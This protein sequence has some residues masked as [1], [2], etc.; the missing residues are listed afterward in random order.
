MGLEIH[1]ETPIQTFYSDPLFDPFGLRSGLDPIAGIP[2]YGLAPLAADLS[3]LALE[4]SELRLESDPH[5]SF[6]GDC[7]RVVDQ[8]G[9]APLAPDLPPFG[10]S[11]EQLL[12][13]YAMTAARL[14]GEL[15]IRFGPCHEG[16]VPFAIDDRSRLSG[17]NGVLAAPDGYELAVE[18][19]EVSLISP[20]SRGL[21]EPATGRAFDLH[22]NC[23]FHNTAI[24]RLLELNPPM[25]A[26]PL[27]F[28]GLPHS[29]H[30]LAWFTASDDGALCFK[31]ACQMFLPLGEGAPGG[32][33]TMPASASPESHQE[34]F[35]ARNSSLHPFLF[36]T[37][38]EHRAAETPPLRQRSPKPTGSAIAEA[39]AE[40]ENTVLQ[41]T[42]LPRETYFGDDFD[43]VSADLG[44]GG[45]A[46]SPLFG[47]VSVQLGRI[48][49]GFVPFRLGFS[50]PSPAFEPKFASL[51]QLLP[52]GTAPG[53]VG[54]RGDFAFAKQLYR[55]RNLSLNTDPYKVSI[56][57]VEVET[58]EIRRAVLRKFL[59]QDLML[60]L[61]QTE[62]RTPTDSFAYSATGAFQLHG[63][64]I[65]LDLAG[66]LTIPYPTGYKF[67][68]PDGGATIA[69]E[70][71]QLT[72]FLRLMAVEATGF[73]PARLDQPVRFG[74]AEHVRGHVALEV[75]FEVTPTGT[76]GVVDVE[77]TL[78]DL[79]VRARGATARGVGWDNLRLL[80]GEFPRGDGSDAIC[81]YYLTT[82]KGGAD[83]QIISTNEDLDFWFV[84]ELAS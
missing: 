27:L 32:P 29:G 56:G 14:R 57:V 67:P 42:C 41:L 25:Q 62:P 59:F 3:S 7:I 10:W 34:E 78:D 83:L 16:R 35:P 55:Q 58:G 2:S 13:G 68:L 40:H 74:G 45:R 9:E 33:L 44:G 22:F 66:A 43:L 71:S 4:D 81:G 70:G 77:L 51:L 28:P 53:L 31:L 26:P 80:S 84:G 23:R 11:G 5:E 47:H 64:Q 12:A 48:V 79:R 24:R 50:P 30:A 1:T 36:L 21:L 20:E 73:E 19:N 72:P 82:G 38:R 8:P 46:Q 63:G 76:P 39:L 60:A 37:C 75:S 54:L 15:F 17:D 52:P 18:E 65:A 61:L 6:F 69:E 49:D